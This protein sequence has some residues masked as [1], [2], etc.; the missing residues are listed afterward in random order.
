V[1][2]TAAAAPALDA[3]CVNPDA[4]FAVPYPSSW[5]VHPA[6]PDRDTESCERFGPEPFDLTQDDDLVWTGQSIYLHMIN[7]CVGTFYEPMSSEP[8]EVGGYP[9]FR[10]EYE[11]GFGA[12]SPA[13]ASLE[14]YVR[15]TPI[16]CQAPDFRNFRATTSADVPAYEAN[17]DLLD[18]MMAGLQF[19]STPDT[20]MDRPRSV[21]PWTLVGLGLLAL[22]GVLVI[23]RRS[24]VVG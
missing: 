5:W 24:R 20:A 11:P 8:R 19:S 1:A 3:W 15:L 18:A 6:D 23:T 10:N 7:G 21:S 9:G 12:E 4:P 17:K 2:P 13:V 16:D 14:Y 22:S